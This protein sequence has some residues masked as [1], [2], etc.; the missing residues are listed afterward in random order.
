MNRLGSLSIGV[1]MGIAFS[2][3][4]LL[5][6]VTVLFGRIGLSRV[7]EDLDLV[8]KDRYPKVQMI[9][10][11][12]TGVFEQAVAARNALLTD[13]PRLSADH[14]GRLL[15]AKGKRLPA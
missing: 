6:L 10:D 8:L 9:S 4:V 3:L 7:G 12:E 2:V 11:V 13:D 15:A 14:L 1:R 5:L